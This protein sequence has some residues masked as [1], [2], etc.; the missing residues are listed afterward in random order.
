[1]IKVRRRSLAVVFAFVTLL[2][3]VL[4]YMCLVGR[5][6]TSRSYLTAKVERQDL[7]DEVLAA[8]M[9]QP[10]K[11][12]EVGAQVSGQLK[13]LHV[14]LGETVKQGQLIAT[15]DPVLL[16]NAVLEA[17]AAEENLIAQRRG[18]AAQ[19]EQATFV[20]QAQ[21]QLLAQDSTAL[22]NFID[23]RTQWE[24]QCANVASLDAQIKEAHIQTES[25][26][27]D[28]GYRES[29]VARAYAYPLA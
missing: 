22:Q 11:Q 5:S 1:M 4:P 29:W 16:Q 14:E 23:A 15:I 24:I 2:V 8:G 27:A 9:L 20:Y 13:T 7:D 26:K 6:R 25:A 17:E 12:I 28:L 19:A 21:K 18:A 10:F 3:S